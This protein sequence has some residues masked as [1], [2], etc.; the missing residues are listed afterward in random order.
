MDTKYIH[1]L[2][3]HFSFPCPPHQENTYR[4]QVLIDELNRTNNT[5][6]ERTSGPEFMDNLK[7]TTQGT[8]QGQRNKNMT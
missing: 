8:A 5:S 3:P 1:H 2:H 4:N 7:K 6:E